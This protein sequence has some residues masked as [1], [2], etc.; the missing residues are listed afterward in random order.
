MNYPKYDPPP[1]I[2]ND[3]VAYFEVEFVKPIDFP[4]MRETHMLAIVH[5]GA[6]RSLEK[7]FVTIEVFTNILR[8]F[9]IEN[10]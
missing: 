10:S 8:Y 6:G 4:A 5:R 3:G 9:N 7:H 2:E 1:P